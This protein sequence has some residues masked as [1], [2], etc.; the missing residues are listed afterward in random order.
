MCILAHASP[1]AATRRPWHGD[2]AAN[3]PF[4][5]NAA[6]TP[7]YRSHHSRY[8]MDP[9]TGAIWT[10]LVAAAQRFDSYDVQTDY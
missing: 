4:G 8:N 10:N 1:H 2:G 7:N 6:Q 3:N 9:Q 5:R